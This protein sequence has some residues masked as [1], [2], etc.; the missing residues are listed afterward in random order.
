MSIERSR[1]GLLVAAFGAIVLAV[2]VFLPWY[3][4]SFT[5]SGVAYIQ[6][7]GDQLVSQ[8]GNSQ[9][10]ALAGP[11]HAG[12]GTLAG[13]QVGAVS[14]HEALKYTN[15]VLLVLAGLALL[16]ALFPLVSA[17]SLPTGA[18]ASLTLVGAVA[19]G[20]VLYRILVPPIPAGGYV[21]LSVREGA[22]LA[23]LGA[24]GVLA[25]GIWPRLARGSGS[26]SQVRAESAF[27]ALSGW[28]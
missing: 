15:I 9:L 8:Y 6:Q 24:L 2:S 22:W 20:W 21:S 4:V 19:S 17:S 3:G 14:A 28:T 12:L 1:F 13:R 11:L 18:G 26:P 10:Q 16:D 27:T 5:A 23:L 25:G 7:V